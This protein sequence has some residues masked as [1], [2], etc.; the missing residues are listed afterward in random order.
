MAA[1]RTKWAAHAHVKRGA[2]H[3]WCSKCPATVRHRA[4][5]STVRADGYGAAV[6][7]LNFLRNSANRRNNRGLHTLAL[8]DLR[9]T[10]RKYG[11][12]RD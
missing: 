4:L 5:S 7:R 8:R 3:G 6:R 11:T 2:L 10:Q 12:S 1:R 9:W